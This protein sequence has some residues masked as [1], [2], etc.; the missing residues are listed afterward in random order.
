MWENDD[1]IRLLK[2]LRA[3]PLYSGEEY[4]NVIAEAGFDR[5]RLNIQLGFRDTKTGACTHLMDD[6]PRQDPKVQENILKAIIAYAKD[7]IGDCHAIEQDLLAIIDPASAHASTQGAETTAPEVTTSPTADEET[8]SPDNDGMPGWIKKKDAWERICKALYFLDLI[9]TENPDDVEITK[10]DV[11]SG[12][13][14]E[15]LLWFIII[16][17]SQG[18]VAK[19][20]KESRARGEWEN[21]RL[22]M[23]TN[24][25]MQIIL[26]VPGQGKMYEEGDFSKRVII[27]RNAA[28]L[29]APGAMVRTLKEFLGQRLSD[30]AADC[31]Q[32]ARRG[33]SHLGFFARENGRVSSTHVDGASPLKWMHFYGNDDEHSKRP[34]IPGELSVIFDEARKDGTGVDWENALELRAEHFRGVSRALPNPLCDVNDYLSEYTGPVFLSRTHNDLNLTNLL[35]SVD[36]TGNPI[37]TLLIDLAD[38]IPNDL[39]VRDF[40]RLEIELWHDL[41]CEVMRRDSL[42]NEIPACLVTMRDV[43]DGRLKTFS[44][45]LPQFAKNFSALISHI[46]EQAAV[47]LNGARPQKEVIGEYLHALYFSFVWALRSERVKK[48]RVKFDAVLLSAALSKEALVEHKDATYV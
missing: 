14:N 48:S 39:T 22:L 11:K 32:A 18:I 6:I 26:P 23:R 4:F 37:E 13:N 29:A 20:D 1:R 31:V 34:N 38:S 16:P 17:G 47:H 36:E 43:L 28:G 40:A 42:L 21:V 25:P 10:F 19:F 7:T 27:S 12:V 41:F 35:V 33:L 46:R 2:A 24:Y 15:S 3:L 5:N 44:D 30:S 8:D 45:D 9:D